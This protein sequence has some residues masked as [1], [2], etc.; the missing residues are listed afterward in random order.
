MGKITQVWESLKTVN[1]LVDVFETCVDFGLNLT[2]SKKVASQ[3]QMRRNGGAS[4]AF[5]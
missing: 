2:T 1:C 4:G 3:W 5:L